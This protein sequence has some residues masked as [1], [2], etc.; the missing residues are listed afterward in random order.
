[1]LFIVSH[2]LLKKKKTDMW[3][4]KN[5]CKLKIQKFQMLSR[6]H[7]LPIKHYTKKKRLIFHPQNR[8]PKTQ[9][10]KLKGNNRNMKLCIYNIHNQL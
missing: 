10:F 1:M 7:L 6:P 5:K 9:K 4:L 3:F 2:E 8:I